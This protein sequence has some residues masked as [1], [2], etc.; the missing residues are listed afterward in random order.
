MKLLIFD[1]ETTGLPKSRQPASNGPN[2]WPHIVSISWIILDTETNTELKRC[3]YI[4]R[5]N[6][7]DIPEDSIRIHGITLEIAQ[8]KGVDLMGAMTEFVKEYSDMWVAHNLEFDM[9]VIVNAFLWDLQIQFPVTPQRKMCTMLLSKPICK[10]PGMY[11]NKYKSPKLKELYHHAFGRYPEE[12][13][14][15]NSMYDVGILT[16]IIKSYLPLRQALGLVARS[17]VKSDGRTL[18]ICLKHSDKEYQSDNDL[19]K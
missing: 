10:M 1:T 11:R 5:P 2:N 14:L 15:H 18:T 6:G 4:I 13:M 7:W 3:N 17:D 9:N 16:D 12:L 8:Q 19:G